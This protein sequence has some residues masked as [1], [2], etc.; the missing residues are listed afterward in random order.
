MNASCSGGRHRGGAPSYVALD[1]PPLV[2]GGGT[3]YIVDYS[4][5]SSWRGLGWSH[6]HENESN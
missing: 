1:Q 3:F 5:D 6:S 4:L 2:D